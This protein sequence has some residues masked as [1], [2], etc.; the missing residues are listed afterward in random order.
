MS[1]AVRVLEPVSAIHSGLHFLTCASFSKTYSQPNVANLPCDHVFQVQFNINIPPPNNDE[2][3]THTPT[4]H[5]KSWPIRKTSPPFMKKLCALYTMGPKTYMFR[6]V[7][8][9]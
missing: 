4:S 2:H 1:K 7:Y 5:Q 9:K 8:G 6:G 3:P